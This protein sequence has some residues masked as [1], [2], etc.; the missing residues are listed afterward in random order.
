MNELN[1]DAQRF[2]TENGHKES[3]IES[4][5]PEQPKNLLAGASVTVHFESRDSFSPPESSQPG[6]GSKENVSHGL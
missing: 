2:S 4:A 1:T 3:I 6:E 5:A